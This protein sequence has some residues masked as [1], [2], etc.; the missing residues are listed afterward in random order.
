MLF[1]I[2]LQLYGVNL[3]DFP[4]LN[5]SVKHLCSSSELPF[6]SRIPHALPVQAFLLLLYIFF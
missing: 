6:S 4:T 1:G 2:H 5:N 3:F